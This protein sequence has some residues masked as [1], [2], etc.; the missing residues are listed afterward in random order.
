MTAT[1][2]REVLDVTPVHSVHPVHETSLRR[3]SDAALAPL[4]GDSALEVQASVDKWKMI[5]KALVQSTTAAQWKDFGNT[6]YMEGDAAL[7]IASVL[8]LTICEPQFE[9]EDLNGGVH[10]CVAMVCV[11]RFGREAFEFGDCDSLDPFLDAK[12]ANL[13]E[14]GAT[15][16]QVT[17]LIRV[18]MKKKALANAISR[19][20]SAW[21]GLRGLSWEDLAELGLR[22]EGV[23]AVSFK[24]G[25]AGKKGG[26][27]PFVSFK[28]LA[29]QTKGSIVATSA[30]V[31]QS[32]SR[33]AGGKDIT[34]YQ[35]E[36]DGIKIKASMWGTA[37]EWA[38]AGTPVAITELKVGEYNG[39]P[40]YTIIAWERS[41]AGGADEG[42]AQ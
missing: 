24:K 34:D 3:M 28:D 16:E 11:T 6:P 41:E 26:Q 17:A 29:A 33:Q 8:G 37:L 31:V 40:Q 7:S 25:V 23:G 4:S 19:A 1:M 32:H 27:K 2:E 42:G 5:R 35:L 30:T 12:K 39:A 18:E 13:S 21:T 9:F 15:P 14:R 10:Q 36:G 20:V 38:V 22:R